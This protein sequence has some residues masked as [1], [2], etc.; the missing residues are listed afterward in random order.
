MAGGPASTTNAEAWPGARLTVPAR[1]SP[2]SRGLK[3]PAAAA[4]DGLMA[5][6]LWALRRLV[7]T[8]R[9]YRTRL[10]VALVVLLGASLAAAFA[11]WHAGR[12][13]ETSY[14]G[15]AK[16]ESL[17]VAKV[18]AGDLTSAD[19][20]QRT[21]LRRRLLRIGEGA[22][23]L[24]Q[25]AVYER[26]SGGLNL[27]ASS[28][29]AGGAASPAAAGRARRLTDGQALYETRHVRGEH[30]SEL[31]YAW[32]P[33][34][35]GSLAVIEIRSRLAALDAALRHSQGNVAWA[36]AV[37]GLMLAALLL[38]VLGATVFRPLGKVQAAARRLAAGQLDARL[39]WRR[40]DE[41]GALGH[42]FDAM[43]SKLE[44][45]HRKLASL[46]L[47]DALTGLANHRHFHHRLAEEMTRARQQS[48]PLALVA[49]DL[50]HFKAVNDTHGHPYGD[51]VLQKAG[52]ALAGVVRTIDTVAR[53][54]G[55]EFAL[56]LPGADA[57]LAYAIAERARDA[58]AGVPLRGTD[59]SFSAGIA[60][61][62]EDA[63]SASSLVEL[64][65]GALYLAKRGGRNQTRLY[66][67]RE[68][69]TSERRS[70]E[71]QQAEI[72]ALLEGGGAI[73]PVFQ[74]IVL[75]ASGEVIGYEALARFAG[76]KRPPD[77]WFAQAHRCGLG[78]VLEAQALQ[79]ALRRPGRP[80]GTLL[81]LNVSPSALSSREVLGV[82]PNDLR[83]ILIEITEH[84]RFSD[85]PSFAGALS[86]IRERGALIAVDDAGAGYAGLHH[87][88]RL[89]PDIIKLDRGLIDGI[90]VDDV[91]AAL[92]E[93]FASF[94]RRTGAELCA[95]GIENLDDLGALREFGVTYGQGYALARPSAGWA[96]V[97]EAA[98]RACRGHRP[99]GAALG[100][101]E[102]QH[103][104]DSKE[105]VPS[106]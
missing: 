35:G 91:K 57:E 98:L 81:S 84:E 89:R 6:L 1:V 51:A 2:G 105:A 21:Q 50:D 4:D 88:M 47:T 9:R 46:A 22:A 106:R 101:E 62:P 103:K 45:S 48:S 61:Y 100:D 78:P 54:G 10:Q 43:A 38:L 97:S 63:W 69:G 19:L 17:A 36:A 31:V 72:S 18:L 82:L 23:N 80:Q 49:L 16:A 96:R 75:L 41:L 65:D 40:H 92:I 42:D 58:I 74:P 5:G 15:A 85:Q 86:T 26:A 79:A 11:S 8:S 44:E 20:R 13:L 104:T 24:P 52:A 94:A 76:S 14:S 53:V 90:A 102:I 60:C 28:A 56:L 32:R 99:A 25:I 3:R 77:A 33:S 39:E 30:V 87:L 93:S 12:E 55:E 64:A 7:G 71:E 83:G 37:S 67:A 29:A 70:R 27:L 66:D 95:E 68:G 59:L 73:T 34:G